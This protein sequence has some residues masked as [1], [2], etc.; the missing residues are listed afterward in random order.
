MSSNNRI[1]MKLES[2]ESRRLLAAQIVEQLVV[3]PPVDPS[4]STATIRGEKLGSEVNDTQSPAVAEFATEAYGAKKGEDGYSA[5]Q[6]FDGDGDIDG[7]DLLK[8]RRE[9]VASNSGGE[10]PS[11]ETPEM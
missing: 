6:D 8:Y 11:V 3:L 10:K 2:L 9:Y 4:G 5:I 1:R 7:L